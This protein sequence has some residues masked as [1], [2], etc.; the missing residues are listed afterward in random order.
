MRLLSRESL[1]S[2][3][4]GQHA[5]MKHISKTIYWVV[6]PCSVGVWVHERF[7]TS[8]RTSGVASDKLWV[9]LVS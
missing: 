4:H 7:Y 1:L 9:E 5:W 8:S 6:L 2:E 3:A